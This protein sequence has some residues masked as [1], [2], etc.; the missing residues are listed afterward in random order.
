MGGVRVFVVCYFSVLVALCACVVC[1]S[2]LG[3]SFV[4]VFVFCLCCDVV[5]GL[6]VW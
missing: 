4:Y 3:V 2:P 1:W 5:C 6:F